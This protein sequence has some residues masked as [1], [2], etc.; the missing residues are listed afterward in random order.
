MKDVD[1]VLAADAN[2]ELHVDAKGHEQQLEPED[3]NIWQPKDATAK[4]RGRSRGR[5][6]RGQGGGRPGEWVLSA[7]TCNAIIVAIKSSSPVLIARIS[8]CLNEQQFGLEVTAKESAD[9]SRWVNSKTAGLL[10]I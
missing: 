2:E 1:Q 7:T 10:F 3:A 5:G 8:F 6:V 4:A 9:V